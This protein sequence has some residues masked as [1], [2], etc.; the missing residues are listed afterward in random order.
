MAHTSECDRKLERKLAGVIA[1]LEPEHR[2]EAVDRFI[3][4]I[5]RKMHLRPEYVVGGQ[6]KA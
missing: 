3:A 2:Q 4:L 5:K 1:D 6:D